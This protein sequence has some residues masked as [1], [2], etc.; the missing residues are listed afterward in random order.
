MAFCNKC[1]VEIENSVKN[2]PNCG[3]A[4]K[5]AATNDIVNEVTNRFN[6]F[7]NTA[8][9]TGEFSQDDINNNKVMGILSYIGILVLIPILAAKDSKFAR[10]HANQGL[11]LFIVNIAWS[12]V[13]AILSSILGAI[14][15]GFIMAILSPIVSILLLALAII[16]IVNVVNG[17]AKELPLI[18]T[19]K[20]LN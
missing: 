11:V 7:N 10:F 18:G 20:F 16:G 3:E 6:Q 4:V 9:S 13:H 5:G 12:I 19:I 14:K 1:G 2:C 17:K 8:D 15:L